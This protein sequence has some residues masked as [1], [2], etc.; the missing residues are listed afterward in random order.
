MSL[1]SFST[2]RSLLEI[3]WASSRIYFA[4]AN[5]I[6]FLPFLPWWPPLPLSFFFPFSYLVTFSFVLCRTYHKQ[7]IYL[8]DPSFSS[9]V[10]TFVLSIF[11]AFQL[12]T[13][14]AQQWCFRK[15]MLYALRQRQPFTCCLRRSLSSILANVVLVHIALFLNFKK[16]SSAISKI[17]YASH[18]QNFHFQIQSFPFPIED[19]FNILL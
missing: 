1:T 7:K 10:G 4:A 3:W 9:K 5:F 18:F 11:C 17:C 14:L 12:L 15:R 16:F 13:Q 19:I 2:A 8:L 6:T